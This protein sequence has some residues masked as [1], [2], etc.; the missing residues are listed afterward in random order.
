MNDSTP[1]ALM[2]SSDQTQPRREFLGQIAASA[3]L[4]ASAA[5]IPSVVAQSQEPSTS[6]PKPSAARP[7]FN[8]PTHWDDSWFDRLTA[9]HKA[10]FD[11]PAIDSGIALW[12][13]MLFIQGMHQ[14]LSAT[15]TDVQA[16]IVIRHAA[17]AMAFNDAM[18][19]KYELGKREKIKDSRTKAWARRNPYLT[20]ETDSMVASPLAW[21]ASHGHVLLG[22]NNATLGYAMQ[23]AKKF[24][25]NPGDVYDELIANLV[26]GMILQPSGVYAVI[27][28][29][30]AGCVFFRRASTE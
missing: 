20:G 30:E 4:I 9:R 2:N 17:M 21:L 23:I 18:W 3:V 27:R 1:S 5:C 14:A 28:A 15:D 25:A 26:P 16:V 12:N 29:Q 22:C 24:K 13:A 19:E 6:T 8:V 10:V 7:K 11:S